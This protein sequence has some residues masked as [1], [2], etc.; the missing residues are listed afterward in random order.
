M[1]QMA[2][3]SSRTYCLERETILNKFGYLGDAAAPR[4]T[5]TPPTGG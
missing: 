4:A 5:Q 1:A 2:G 3:H